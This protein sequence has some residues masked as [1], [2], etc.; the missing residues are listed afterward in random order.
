MKRDVMN[1]KLS[2]MAFGV[3]GIGDAI[4]RI[5]EELNEYYSQRKK[6]LTEL[7]DIPRVKHYHD[8]LQAPDHR[9]QQSLAHLASALK[10][11]GADI[12]EVDNEY[13]RKGA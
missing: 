3:L 10:I 4:D 11:L 5:V 8:F 13:Q 9:V 1:V 7:N 12:A 2:D 6:L